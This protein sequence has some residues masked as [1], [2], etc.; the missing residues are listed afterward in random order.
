MSSPI[1]ILLVEEDP[2]KRDR[3][4]LLLAPDWERPSGRSSGKHGPV[5]RHDDE[6][7]SR[8]T[9]PRLAIVVRASEAQA[10][11]TIR[12]GLK[13][14][15]PFALLFCGLPE[16]H[17]EKMAATARRL[18]ALDPRMGLLLIAERKDFPWDELPFPP[19]EPVLLLH[20]PLIPAELRRLILTLG[21]S[22]QPLCE[23]PWQR[24]ESKLQVL[25]KLDP[26]T[27]PAPPADLP[28]LDLARLESTFETLCSAYYRRFGELL[29]LQE[30][31]GIESRLRRMAEIQRRRDHQ[32]RLAI[33]RLMETAMDQLP[34]EKQLGMILEVIFTVPWFARMP[35]GA[36]FLVDDASGALKLAAQSGFSEE[37]STRCAVIQ[38]GECLCGRALRDQEMIFSSC[39]DEH[40][41][42][43]FDHMPPHGH[44]CV[45]ITNRERTVGVINLY[46]EPNHVQ[47]AEEREFLSNVA[48]TTLGLLER[49]QLE[50]KLE[51]RDQLAQLDELTG[52]ANRALFQDRL[53]RAMS[54]AARQQRQL[55]LMVLDLD[56][57][58][59]VNDTL[60]HD[61]GDQLL[62][63][64]ALRIRDCLRHSDSVS[65]LGGDEF[66]IILPELTHPFYVELVARKILEQTAKPFVFPM[67]E[68]KL[69]CSIGLAVYPDD[70]ETV[71]DLLKNAD[72]AMYRA[73]S[74]GKE[75]FRFFKPE[76]SRLARHRMEMEMAM[77]R[78]LE[79]HEFELFYQPKIDL[80]QNRVIGMEALVRW[81]H[82]E[83]GII[84][85]VEFI[86]IAEE[87][88]LILPLGAWILRT[89]CR[90]TQQWRA[91]G[92]EELKVSVNLSARQFQQQDELL[93][94]LR[95]SLEDSGLP[96]HA[97][98]LE[99]TENMVMD[100]AA[101]TIAALREIRAMG[102][103]I[104]VDDFGTG[105]SSLSYLKKFPIQV[106]KIDQSFVRDLGVN[107]EDEAIVTSIIALARNMNLEV[108]A[109][110]VENLVQ[111]SFLQDQGCHRIQGFLHAKP[112]SIDDFLLFLQNRL[113]FPTPLDPP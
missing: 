28:P 90:Q 101:Q 23:I 22:P 108:V 60:G 98:G 3:F 4:A 70:G 109:E 17:P 111:Q 77:R 30:E 74:E 112:L 16:K 78:G 19:H 54:L 18:A 13:T 105:Y 87:S 66:A 53:S 52:L 102:V 45:P 55:V 1:R 95:Q 49:R 110:G 51:E 43:R 14:A 73:K 61:A 93:E 83:R 11:E 10:E 26:D 24:F 8:S 5:S 21:K 29:T 48:Q 81:R 106:L 38:P 69:S 59:M 7:S 91:M 12:H 82:P 46:V 97:L 57:F 89:A 33:I 32:N 64:A 47:T 86:P 72:N 71:G 65:R 75:T 103:E 40:H 2:V 85:P 31:V 100:N 41:D 58:K 36:I 79:R 62:R 50:E 67:G 88:G 20:H 84:S 104:L 68:V 94:L 37:Q 92:F 34:L 76:M 27:F 39:V 99:L 15:A 35:K 56:R 6:K 25:R 42:I 96:P 107:R 9:A 63:E 113:P 44:Y 80:D